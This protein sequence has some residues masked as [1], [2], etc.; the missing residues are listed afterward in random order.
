MLRKLLIIAIAAV[1][2]SGSVGCCMCDHVDDY[3]GCYYGGAIGNW[4][5]DTGRAGSAYSGSATSE[6]PVLI[7]QE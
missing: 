2:G 3:D 5:G 4:D 6:A 7:E 1:S